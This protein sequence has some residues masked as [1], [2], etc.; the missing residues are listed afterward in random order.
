MST[1]AKDAAK[2]ANTLLEFSGDNQ[3]ALL[4]VMT[5][6]FT[7][8]DE[9]R[10][11][12]SDEDDVSNNEQAQLQGRT[13]INTKHDTI[14]MTMNIKSQTSTHCAEQLDGEPGGADVSASSQE[15]DVSSEGDEV[16]DMETRVREATQCLQT[17]DDSSITTGLPTDTLEHKAVSQF[18]TSGYGCTKA[19]RKPCCEHFCQEYVTSIRSPVPSISFVPFLGF[20]LSLS[21]FSISSL[22][23]FPLLTTVMS[24][25]LG[26]LRMKLFAWNL[27]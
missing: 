24:S 2:V 26:A 7:S 4:E 10:D 20:S 5:D 23:F 9:G 1:L 19:K 3:Q 27:C 22:T 25:G 21:F 6:Y 8:P 13:R 14:M 16:V 18:M 15:T 11:S 17:N 12:D